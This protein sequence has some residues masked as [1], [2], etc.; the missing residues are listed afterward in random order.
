MRR[1]TVA[2]RR[3]RRGWGRTVPEPTYL[4]REPHDPPNTGSR[5]EADSAA[6]AAEKY[7]EDAFEGEPD[8]ERR[9]VVQT[10]AYPEEVAFVVTIATETTFTA[11]LAEGVAP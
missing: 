1:W 9:V 11:R 4:C 5:I 2:P 3:W 6:R 10:L 7:V 8:G